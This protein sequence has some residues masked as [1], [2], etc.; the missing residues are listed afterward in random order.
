[1]LR[2]VRSVALIVC[3]AVLS[4]LPEPLASRVARL[5]PARGGQQWERDA[6][7]LSPAGATLL[8]ATTVP[9]DSWRFLWDAP[10]FD[11]LFRGK[12][13]SDRK[14]DDDKRRERFQV[15]SKELLV[16]VCGRLDGVD[17]DAAGRMAA[18]LVHDFG[19]RRGP[20]A[21]IPLDDEQRLGM[22]ATERGCTRALLQ[23]VIPDA[24]REARE[25]KQLRTK[26]EA[27]ETRM[28]A[29]DSKLDA[30]LEAL[31]R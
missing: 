3:D 6:F 15:C 23:H 21:S 2:T 27:M 11:G 1:M 19:Y 20:D 12:R 14:D 30:V 26:I 5:R 31:L 4:R 17:G 16:K 9:T 13:S 7:A 8:G 22:S 25:N 28:R 10:L 29:M 24:K 18:A